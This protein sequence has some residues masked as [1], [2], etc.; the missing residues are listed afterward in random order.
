MNR[1][2]LYQKTGFNSEFIHTLLHNEYDSYIKK[3]YKR[4]LGDMSVISTDLVIE[5]T[6]N[7][8]QEISTETDISILVFDCIRKD[9]FYRISKDTE[10]RKKIGLHSLKNCT[11]L[12]DDTK[13]SLALKI[14]LSLL[15]RKQQKY[16]FDK[17]YYLKN[18]KAIKKYDRVIKKLFAGKGVAK[19]KFKFFKIKPIQTDDDWY[20]NCFQ[21]LNFSSLHFLSNGRVLIV[22]NEISKM[23][24]FYDLLERQHRISSA[25]VKILLA[26]ILCLGVLYIVF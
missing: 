22:S 21:N 25:V 19:Y 2:E 17:F 8:L 15:S 3:E 1:I 20:I 10:L 5:N 12:F 18:I 16:F 7:R 26:L 9:V 24:L 13:Q 6:Y 4:I 14:V 23:P 11:N